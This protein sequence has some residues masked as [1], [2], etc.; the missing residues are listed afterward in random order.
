V[1]KESIAQ[2][3]TDALSSLAMERDIAESITREL[4]AFVALL[5]ANPTIAAFFTSPVVE[6]ERK[7]EL[8]RH[9]LEGRASDLLLHFLL[10]LV[11]K[12]RERL[13]PIVAHQ[14]HEFLDRKAGREIAA[15][16]SPMA[17]GAQQLE[18][19]ARRLSA[20]YDATIVP[21]TKIAPDLLGGLVV[22]VGDRYVDASVSGRLEELRRHLLESADTWGAASPNGQP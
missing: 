15:I 22:Q 7:I 10:L 11:R 18:E 8:L 21:Q 16:A 13:L 17:L 4:D 2:R 5:D 1:L 12:H 9:A 19:L 14:M 3:Y 6:R 20:V